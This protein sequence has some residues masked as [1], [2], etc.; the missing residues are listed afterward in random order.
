MLDASEH[1]KDIVD[2][3]NACDKRYI[4]EQMCMIR[5][6]EADDNKKKEWML[7]QWLGI[8]I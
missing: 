7:I 6:P 1:G 8:K 2:A 4:K 5:T 3:I